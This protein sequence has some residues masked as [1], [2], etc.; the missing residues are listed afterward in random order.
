[1]SGTVAPVP[2][3]T[4]LDT[5]GDPLVSGKLYSYA[6]GTS[7][8]IATYTSST[9][10]TPNANPVIADAAG[11]VEIWLSP[12][13]AY[14]FQCDNS[15]DVTQWTVDNVEGVPLTNLALDIQG[16]AG[17]NLAAGDGV[18]M[19][20]GGGGGT[21]GRWYRTDADNTYSS[22][23]APMAGMVQDAISSAATGSIRLQGRITGLSGLTPGTIYYA[24]AT[25]GALTAS[26][27]A[28]SLYMGAADSSTTFV[29]QP[30][31]SATSA[32]EARVTTAEADIVVL[33]GLT[34][35]ASGSVPGIVSTGTQTFAG[36]K[37]FASNVTVTGTSTLTGQSTFAVP[38]K[39]F[40][41]ATSTA[42]IIPNALLSSSGTTYTE[43][44][45]GL[46]TAYSFTV[47][48]GT[49]DV[50]NKCLRVVFWGVGANNANAKTINV[51]LGSTSI[52]VFSSAIQGVNLRGELVII[53][54]GAA[55]QRVIG[56]RSTDGATTTNLVVL[57]NAWTETLANDLVLYIK[58]QGGAASDIILYG[59]TVE[60]MG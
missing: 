3:W 17:E 20:D 18:Y 45:T 37:T 24:S 35:D 21:A 6:A 51:V 25:A 29:L 38:P 32:L 40:P 54:T 23:S 28:N 26:S 46:E 31:A 44:G 27:P 53:R 15:S 50:D 8:P 58:I 56:W 36:A 12:G 34:V 19:S 9:L 52:T 49:L 47:K 5:N 13:T 1:M 22:S 43:T 59:Y 57:S 55:T 11:R 7:T 60:T 10:A 48:G 14:K 39:F 42:A 2:I 33:E 16:T 41:G 30:S 4:L